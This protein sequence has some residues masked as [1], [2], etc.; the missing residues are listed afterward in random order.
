MLVLMHGPH[1]AEA[2]CIGKFHKNRVSKK[3]GGEGA[4]MSINWGMDVQKVLQIF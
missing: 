3:G 4:L 1:C 2:L